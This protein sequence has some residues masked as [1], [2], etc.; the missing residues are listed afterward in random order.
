MYAI[1][2][3][4]RLQSHF[5][6]SHIRRVHMCLSV[7]CH[8]HFGQNGRDRLRSAAVTCYCGGPETEIRV[9]RESR[10][11][12]KRFFRRSCKDSNTRPSSDEPR[13]PPL[14]YPRHG[15]TRQCRYIRHKS[16]ITYLFFKVFSV[17]AAYVLWSI[18]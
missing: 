9:S 4:T 14:S 15:Y 16:S 12:R 2:P 13:A 18:L 8:L 5:I 7:T 1:P 3:C 17:T 11:W 10:P 6:R